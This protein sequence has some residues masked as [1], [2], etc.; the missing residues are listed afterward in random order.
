[1]ATR[2]TSSRKLF[3]IV[4]IL[5]ITASCTYSLV[6]LAE[7]LTTRVSV[8]S[9]NVESQLTPRTKHRLYEGLPHQYWRKNELESERRLKRTIK[10]QGFDFYAQ[11][12][13]LAEIDLVAIRD[14]L[15]NPKAYETYRS[16][17]LCGGYHPDF[18]LVWQCSDGDLQFHVCF[19]CEE[20][21]VRQGN[22]LAH[23]DLSW[24]AA[25]ALKKTLQKYQFQLPMEQQ[26][27]QSDA[28]PSG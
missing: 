28:H 17:K 8:A 14:I 5:I 13:Q 6:P 20:V 3:L 22:R 15:V 9:L 27:S 21:K 2:T 12:N 25:N 1:M 11:P 23:C 26:G 24:D 19:G 7:A 4:L 10:M 18:A 16:G